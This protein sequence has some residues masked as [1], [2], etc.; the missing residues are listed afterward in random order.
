MKGGFNTTIKKLD[1]SEVKELRNKGYE[2]LIFQGCGG[3]LDDWIEGVTGLLKENN[4]VPSDFQFDEVYSFENNDVTNLA[5]GLNNK[6]INMSKL[7]IF[8]IKIRETFDAIWL[9]DYIDNGY[10]KEIN[11]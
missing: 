9:S 11:I 3:E 2:F 7:A 8:R 10:I 6:D 5:F 1:I 4:I